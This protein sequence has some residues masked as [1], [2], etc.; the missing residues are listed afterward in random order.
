[1]HLKSLEN[2]LQS[3]KRN[4]P[5]LKLKSDYLDELAAALQNMK[6]ITVQYKIFSK[7]GGNLEPIVDGTSKDQ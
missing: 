4:I 7:V 3:A 5:A 6:T 1:M 2:A